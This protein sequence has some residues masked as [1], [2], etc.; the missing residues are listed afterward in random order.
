MQNAQKAC[1]LEQIQQGSEV[2][3]GK[4]EWFSQPA[5]DIDTEE[6]SLGRWKCTKVFCC[7]WS[8]A[9][10]A[11]LAANK[12]LFWFGCCGE[13]MQKDLWLDR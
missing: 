5:C 3:L 7:H 8:W 1:D 4:H 11:S 2:G 13:V 12:E 6:K 10:F 9:D